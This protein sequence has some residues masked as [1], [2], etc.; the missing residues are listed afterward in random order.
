MRDL[1]SIAAAD[2]FYREIFGLELAMGHGWLRTYVSAGKMTVQV[3]FAS[4][5]GSGTPVPLLSIEVDDLAEALRRVEASGRPLECGPVSE[6]WACAGSTSET[7]SA[8]SSMCCSM[9]SRASASA[10]VRVNRVERSTQLDRAARR[11]GGWPNLIGQWIQAPIS[12]G[13]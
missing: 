1:F 9:N 10:L 5:G 3:S 4:Q 13:A 7:P 2:T 8:I 11:G 12:H 6:P